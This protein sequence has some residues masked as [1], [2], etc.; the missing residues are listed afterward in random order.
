[1]EDAVSE[2]VAQSIRLQLNGKEKKRFAKR[3]T[4]SG[5]AYQAYIRGRYFWNK[6]TDEGMKKGLAYFR[7]AI[8]LDPTFAQAYVGVADSYAT[9]GLYAVL[10]PKEAFPAAKEAGKEKPRHGDRFAQTH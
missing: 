8:A 6:R 9:L 3:P 1:M 7:E 2:H 10:P 5:E 4:D